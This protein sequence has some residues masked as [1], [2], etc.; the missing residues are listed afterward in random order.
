VGPFITTCPS[1]A[2][3]FQ[4]EAGILSAH[5]TGVQTCALP[6]SNSW[7]SLRAATRSGPVRTRTPAARSAQNPLPL[8]LGSGSRM[9]ATTSPTR[10]EERRVGIEGRYRGIPYG[11]NK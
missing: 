3:F 6:I 11:D 5:V 4:A 10:S 1:V 7:L 2:L 9:L 8:T